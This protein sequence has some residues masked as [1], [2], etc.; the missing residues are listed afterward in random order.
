MVLASLHA[1]A[2]CVK[3]PSHEAAR[4][5]EVDWFQGRVIESR[6]QKSMVV[7][8]RVVVAIF[9]VAFFAVAL[10]VVKAGL[11]EDS[12]GLATVGGVLALGA[13]GLIWAGLTSKGRDVCEA[14]VLLISR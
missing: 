12:L 14:A 13:L 6:A 4:K 3:P 5:R 7:V 2:L 10:L 9:G 11:N 1:Y 8:C